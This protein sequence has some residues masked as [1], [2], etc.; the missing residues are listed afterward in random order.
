MKAL[1]IILIVLLATPLCAQ[2]PAPGAEQSKPII[3][4]NGTAHIG[5]GEVIEN[6]AVAFEEGKLTIVGDATT[7]RIDMGKFEVIDCQGKHIY[8]GI[9]AANTQL[10][11]VEIGA[12]RATHDEDEVGGFNPNIRS[13]I[14]YNTDSRVTPTIRSNGILLAQTVPQGGWISG[15]SSVVQLDAWNWEDAAVRADDGIWL[16]WPSWFE[17]RGWWAEP[18]P[19]EKNKRY[20][21]QVEEIMDFMTQAQAYLEQ[22]GVDK[23]NLKF[24]GMRKVLSGEANLYVRVGYVRA[25]LDAMNRLGKFSQDLNIVLV[26]ARDADLIVDELA[27]SGVQVILSET[28]R[29]PAYDHSDVNSQYQTP[30]LLAEASIDFCLSGDGYWQQRNLMFHAGTAV[31]HGMDYERAIQMITYDAARILGIA[32]NYGSLETGKSATVIVSSGD[33]LDMMSSHIEHAF[34]DGRQVNLTNKQKELYEKFSGKYG[35]E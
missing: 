32:D 21:Q 1:Q 33:V 16:S 30:A 13:L 9:I 8:P 15:Q 4:M 17:R 20:D 26:G 35:L 31:A 14:A 27:L 10:G 5:N 7:M 12:V 34:I 11:L 6:A 19:T 29:L 25:M 2:V 24:E 28:H 22:D 18:G 3:L 23:T